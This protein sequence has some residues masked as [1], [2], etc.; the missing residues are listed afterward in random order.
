MG[1]EEGVGAGAG[2]EL[3]VAVVGGEN[4]GRAIGGVG[5]GADGDS[6]WVGFAVGSVNGA[7]YEGAAFESEGVGAGAEL[8]EILCGVEVQR[9]EA[10][11]V[12][13]ERMGGAEDELVVGFGDGSEAPFAVGVG[14][15]G[16]GGGGDLYGGLVLLLDSGE[17]GCAGERVALE[18]ED[19]A[20][21][22]DGFFELEG[23]NGRVRCPQAQPLPADFY[24]DVTLFG[25]SYGEVVGE[26]RR[27]RKTGSAVRSGF[28]AGGGSVHSW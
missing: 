21:D 8:S 3:E 5:P 17:H 27:I 28:G 12:K 2:G 26:G 25:G 14:G 15:G 23:K 1:G 22:C 6:G 18:I 19:A 9:D 24:G 10:A 7:G 16:E 20:T 4:I 13:T 11:A